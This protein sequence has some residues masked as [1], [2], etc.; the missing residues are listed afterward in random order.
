[1]I[2][3]LYS[4]GIVAAVVFGLYIGPHAADSGEIN[5][6]G[7]SPC[8]A[9]TV[10]PMGCGGCPFIMLGFTFGHRIQCAYY[11]APQC[12]GGGCLVTF[13]SIQCD[14]DCTP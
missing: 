8:N 2:R 6:M 12:S 3:W 10:F 11:Q 13:Q 5:S 14:G 7:G 1:M 4:V 9:D